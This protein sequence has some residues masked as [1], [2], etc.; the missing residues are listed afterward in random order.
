MQP[1]FN[2]TP[3]TA[4]NNNSKVRPLQSNIR[5]GSAIKSPRNN[6]VLSQSVVLDKKP[7]TLQKAN[8]PLNKSQFITKENLSKSN[9]LLNASLFKSGAPKSPG[10]QASTNL[11]I[12]PKPF[13]EVEQ[14]KIDP[15]VQT[16]P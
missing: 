5:P 10:N 3:L 12:Q 16:A 6:P 15:Q 1:K 9:A 13:N 7:L 4:N 2:F 11:F 14:I 8:N